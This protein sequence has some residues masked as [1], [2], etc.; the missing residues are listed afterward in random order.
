V[1]TSIG[2]IFGLACGFVSPGAMSIAK[3]VPLI[4]ATCIIILLQSC[5][6]QTKNT[7]E[8]MILARDSSDHL[9]PINSSGQPTSRRARADIS[10]QGIEMSGGNGFAFF[11]TGFSWVSGWSVK[12]CDVNG[13]GFDDVIAGAPTAPSI[14]QVGFSSQTVQKG[15]RIHIIFGKPSGWSQQMFQSSLT[16]ENGFTILG[17]YSGGGL[18]YD[19][20]CADV[21]ND[22]F[23]DIITSSPWSGAIHVVFGKASNWAAQVILENLDGTSGF[24]IKASY[25]VNVGFG[26]TSCDINA[27]GIADIIFSGTVQ[28][29]TIHVLFGKQTGWTRQMSLSS[30]ESPNGFNI[31]FT[32]D[33]SGTRLTSYNLTCGDINGDG[34]DDIIIGAPTNKGGSTISP[35]G[36]VHVIFGK[37]D[38]WPDTIYTSSLNGDNGFKVFG[39]TDGSQMGKALSTGD[40][41]GDGYE[42]IIIGAPEAGGGDHDYISLTASAGE[43]IIVFG[44]ASFSGIPIIRDFTEDASSLFM[45]IGSLEKENIGRAVAAADMNGDGIKD[46]IFAAQCKDKTLGI[47]DV[48]CVY[49]VFGRAGTPDEWVTRA[50]AAWTRLVDLKNDQGFVIHGDNWNGHAGKAITTGDINGDGRPDIVFG[51]PFGFTDTEEAGTLF[52]SG[53]V[54]VVFGP[55][56]VRQPIAQQVHVH[57]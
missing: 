25:N 17:P 31:M 34:I 39:R 57:A 18:G 23:N 19:I 45:I 51:E 36:E 55:T 52:D 49:T 38:A 12:A 27:D 48:G 6:G 21:N 43:V 8:G 26:L 11:G 22:G 13:D 24:E 1:L 30:L 47:F 9:I 4:L 56:Q 16:G 50:G 29:K 40:F 20:A 44:R 14:H 15:G 53:T 42:D 2:I 10:I 46:I 37:G 35:R 5:S 54:F 7:Q 33:Y 41:N 28:T 3:A 32:E